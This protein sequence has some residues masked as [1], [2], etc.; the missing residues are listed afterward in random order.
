MEQSF[1]VL[2]Q[3]V[4]KAADL[5]RQLKRDNHA[6]GEDLAKAKGRLADAEKRLAGLE[7]EQGVSAE[8]TR[9]AEVL[10]REVSSLRQEREQIRGRIAKLLELLESLD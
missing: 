8:R 10:G 2:E 5:V 4:K 6:L 9:E 3:K 7:K 1:D